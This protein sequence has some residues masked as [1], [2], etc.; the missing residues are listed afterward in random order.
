VLHR[1]WVLAAAAMGALGVLVMWLA[2]EP[3]IRIVFG[4]EY[5]EASDLAVVLAV[6]QAVRGVTAVYN[7]FM[8]ATALGAAMRNAALVLT[9]SNVVLNFALIPPYG[10]IGA[11]WASVL[12]LIANYFAR[13]YYYRRAIRERPEGFDYREAP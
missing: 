13:I 5:V 6:A 10:A 12:A 8:A 9:V 2:A 7:N 3:A 1:K 11:A 4:E